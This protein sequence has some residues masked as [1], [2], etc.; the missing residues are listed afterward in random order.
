MKTHSSTPVVGT[1]LVIFLT[2]F[3]L[4]A[5]FLF[6]SYLVPSFDG[7]ANTEYSAWDV[8]YSANQG[9]NY[10]DFAAPNGLFQSASS[11]GFTPPTG[12]S[13]SDPPAFWDVENPTITQTG[14]ATAFIIS[15]GITGNIYSFSEATGF[16]LEDTTPYSVETVIFQF[17]TDG[18]LVDFDGIRLIVND[19]S[20]EVA[21]PAD[22]FIREYRSSGSAFGGTSNRNALQW[23]LRGLG[24]Q[25]Y[26]LEWNALGSSMSL[27]NASVDTSASYS[28][29]VPEKRTWTTSGA[30]AWNNGVNWAEGT[31]SQPNGNVLFQN[32]GPVT[33]TDSSSRT[34]GEIVFESDQS[35]D[36]NLSAPLTTQTGVSSHPSATGSYNL[37]GSLIFG[38][39]NVFQ[40]EGGSVFLNGPVSGPHGLLKQGAGTLTLSANNTFGGTTGGVSVEGGTLVLQG[41]NTFPGSTSV[42]EGDLVVGTDVPIGSPGALGSASTNLS[43]GAN[44]GVFSGITT[45]ARFILDGDQLMAR[46]ID[47]APGDFDKQI[48]TRNTA[49]GSQVSGAVQ[50]FSNS[51]EVGFFAESPGDL[52]DFSGPVSGGGSA[53]RLE[54]NGGGQSGTVRF[55]GV[56]KTF[57]NTTTVQGG[58]LEIASGVSMAADVTVAP[59]GGNTRAVLRGDGEVTGSLAVE[60]GG[61]VAPGSSPGTLASGNTDWGPGGAYQFEILSTSGTPGSDWDFLDVSGAMTISATSQN[62]FVIE[63]TSLKSVAEEGLLSTFSPAVP[64]SWKILETDGG[65]SGLSADNVV[66]NLS[67]FENPTGGGTFSVSLENGGLDL[68][69]NFTPATTPLNTWLQNEFTSGELLDITLSGD[70]ADFDGDGLSTLMEYALGGLAKTRDEGLLPSVAV[71][72]PSFGGPED[73]YLTFSFTRLLDRTDIV[74]R[75]KAGPGPDSLNTTVVEINLGGAPTAVNG[76]QVQTGAIQGNLQT[77]TAADSVRVQ[78]A[79]RRFMTLEIQRP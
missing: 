14:T 34:L 78:D 58:T 77:V 76:G 25:T 20:G 50:F 31:A 69:L 36:L 4:R 40:V 45:P 29:E 17:Q 1:G 33:V 72:D 52:L 60:E 56:N 13:P 68:Y 44:S 2:L 35:V 42:I 49:A 7:D 9:I 54:I 61:V 26:R 43:L 75:V 37:N 71:I 66:V 62:P 38:A 67:G 23:D 64:F 32:P 22:E 19:G 47:L 48:G 15:P 16:E 39:F 5:E 59:G 28:S 63:L 70:D 24:I 6:D 12:S 11:A 79:S 41:T 27:Q 73:E 55:S 8:F 30:R 18:S 65:I 21:L 10:P 46:G 51:S 53:H 57:L 74:Y 3:P